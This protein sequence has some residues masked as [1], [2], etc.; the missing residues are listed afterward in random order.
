M[1]GD[2]HLLKE[3]GASYDAFKRKLSMRIEAT[4]KLFT[5]EEYY[6]MAAAGILQP[7]ERVELIEGEIFQM[8]PIGN[9]HVGCVIRA[10]RLFL[11][12]LMGRAVVSGQH[13]VQLSNYTEPQPDL[14][15]LKFRTDDY[16]GKKVVAED[17]LLILEVSD[18]TLRF[19]RN[20]KL[21]RYAAAGISEVWIENLEADELLVYRDPDGEHYRTALTLHRG[22]S[23]SVLAFPDAVFSVD[24]L[25]G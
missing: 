19:D 6:G 13:P 24:E 8:S 10:T 11:T 12:A 23:V 22:D 20:V 7:G 4:R 21:P 17:V 9:R 14:S 18:T 5:V 2:L 3:A 16:S 15:L 1:E 25:L